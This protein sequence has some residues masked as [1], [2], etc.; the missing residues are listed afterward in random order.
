V[1]LSRSS[2]EVEYRGIA[3]VIAETA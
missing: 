1:T 3:N 2:A